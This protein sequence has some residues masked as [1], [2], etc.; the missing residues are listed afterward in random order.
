MAI[1]LTSINGK[2]TVSQYREYLCDSE[3]DIA[4]LPKY[5]IKG[6]LT[7]DTSDIMSNDPC[8]IGSKA[9][10]CVTGDVWILSPSNEWVKVGS[11]NSGKGASVGKPVIFYPTLNG[12]ATSPNADNKASA[13]SILDAYYAGNAYMYLSDIGQKLA[14]I[15]KINGFYISGYVFVETNN[16]NNSSSGIYGVCTME[17]YTAYLNKFLAQ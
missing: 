13:E 17:E 6:N 5:G 12:L 16:L 8:A 4:L 15:E 14:G 7:D 9:M 2:S 1:K 3:A 11:E 10:V